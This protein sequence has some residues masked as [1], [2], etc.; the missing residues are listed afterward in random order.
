[1]NEKDWILL[2]TLFD[3]KSISKA[4]QSLYISQPALS[5]RLQ[6]IE[7]RFNTQIVVRG[8]KGVQFT[9]EGEYLVKTA[10]EIL[11]RIQT[12]E[13]DIQNMKEIPT[14]TLRIGASHFFTKHILPDLLSRF[15]EQYPQIEFRVITNWSKEIV[16][17]TQNHDVHIGFI[18]GDYSWPGE[19]KVLFE[20]KMYITS[21]NKFSLIDL[22][23][24]PKI[25]YHS[26]PSIQLL[27]DKWW[28][29]HFSQPPF[30]GME[31]DKVDT[32]KE[33]VSKGL[34]YAFLPETIFQDMSQFCN[35]QMF[36]KS[37]KP[38]LRKTW[39]LY[40]EETAKL[41]LFKAFLDFI[42]K[43]KFNLV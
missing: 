17:L 12:C 8:K 30:I 22:P 39:M 25:N 20:E 34:G 3:K 37:G 4:S 21:L 40:Y 15:K 1:M 18:R 11:N 43:V 2:K 41:K 6:Q 26:D 14:G 13:E 19:K 33:M 32:C 27:L 38:L 31:V 5:T 9:S 35:Y 29:Q 7:E 24:M 36:Y 28:N 23:C 42:Q 16:N 10:C